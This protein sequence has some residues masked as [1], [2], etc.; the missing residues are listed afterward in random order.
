[1]SFAKHSFDFHFHPHPL[2]H[3]DDLL[4][5]AAKLHIWAIIGV[6]LFLLLGGLEF[7]H[8][9]NNPPQVFPHGSTLRPRVGRGA[10]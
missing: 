2:I 8:L 9:Y 4:K 1:M 10:D 5:R 6:L 3:V 7:V